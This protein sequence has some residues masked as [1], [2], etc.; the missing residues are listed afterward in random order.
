MCVCSV[1]ECVCSVSLTIYILLCCLGVLPHEYLS[2][3]SIILVT[4]FTQSW[5]THCTHFIC[6]ES[7]ASS[8]ST[9]NHYVLSVSSLSIRFVNFEKKPGTR[10]TASILKQ[11]PNL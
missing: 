3:L 9:I 5:P 4:V 10:M 8:F 1:S 2:V 11:D 7:V 6:D